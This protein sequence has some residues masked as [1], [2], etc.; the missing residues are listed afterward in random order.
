MTPVELAEAIDAAALEPS[1]VTEEGLHEL[2]AR[3]APL[4]DALLAADLRA[5]DAGDRLR[6]RACLERARERD[7]QLIEALA[8]FR[9]RVGEQLGAVVE[10]R[11]AVRGYRGAPRTAGA[12]LR[13]A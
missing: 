11:S 2:L 9:D 12:V 7:A 1:E 10:G 3:R 13:T 5:L 4:L 6:V 8:A